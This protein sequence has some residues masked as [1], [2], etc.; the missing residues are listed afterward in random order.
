MRALRPV[1]KKG[2]RSA[3]YIAQEDL[4]VVNAVGLRLLLLLDD[5]GLDILTWLSNF[6][7][8]RYRRNR[9]QNDVRK[10]RSNK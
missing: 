2:I 5:T 6:L 8:R 7:K 3:K 9:G 10:F 1:W 4:F